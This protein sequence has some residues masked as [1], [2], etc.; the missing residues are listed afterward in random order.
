V[1]GQW[2]NIDW[3]A[4]SLNTL[5]DG[6][7]Y[8]NIFDMAKWDEALSSEKILKRSTLDAMW[9]PIKLNNGETF[10]QGLCFRIDNVN[11]HRPAWKDG[12]LQGYTTIMSRYLDDHLTVVVFTNLGE[13]PTIPQHIAERIAAI[14]IPGFT[15]R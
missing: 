3:I 14:Y 12:Q 6:D 13:D 5:A 10:P 11:G 15:D 9:R 8:S 7:E 4:P 1:N 2:K